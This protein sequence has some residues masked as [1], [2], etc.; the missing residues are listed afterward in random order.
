MECIVIGIRLAIHSIMWVWNHQQG[1]CI[2]AGWSMASLAFAMRCSYNMNILFHNMI[3][4]SRPNKNRSQT[5]SFWMLW[6]MIDPHKVSCRFL[7]I[8][9]FLCVIATLQ[10]CFRNSHRLLAEGF[11]MLRQLTNFRFDLWNPFVALD[12]FLAQSLKWFLHDMAC[13]CN[14][15]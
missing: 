15:I 11:H 10:G 12:N 6:F 3:R 14:Y 13:Y 5:W 7:E 8:I 9:A 4:S 1:Q 2:R